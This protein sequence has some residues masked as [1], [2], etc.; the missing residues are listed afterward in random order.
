MRFELARERTLFLCG[1]GAEGRTGQRQ[2]PVQ[3]RIQVDLRLRAADE[4][5]LKETPVQCQAVDV[6]LEVVTSDNVENH[7]DAAA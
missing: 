3:D 6:P 7:V 2:P 5:D 1:A 4:T